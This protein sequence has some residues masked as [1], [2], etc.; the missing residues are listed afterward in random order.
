MFL[1]PLSIEK[2]IFACWFSATSA[3]LTSCSHTK[4]NSYSDISPATALSEPTLYRL[5][6]HVPNLMFIFLS[7]C[8]FTKEPFQA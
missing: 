7:L 1:I 5:T 3:H 6:F 4:S 8:R 2:C